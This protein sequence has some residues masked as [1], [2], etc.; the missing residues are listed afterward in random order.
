LWWNVWYLGSAL[1]MS[2]GRWDDCM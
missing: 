1:K 2:H